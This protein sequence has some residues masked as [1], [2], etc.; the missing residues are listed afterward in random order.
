MDLPR[1]QTMTSAYAAVYKNTDQLDEVAPA[2]A[3]LAGKAAG[4]LAAKG[5]GA[6]AAKM[7]GTAAKMASSKLGQKAIGAGSQAVGNKVQSSL[8][9]EEVEEGSYTSAYL[10]G[11]KPMDLNKMQDKAAMKPDTAKGEKQARKI[12]KIR[13][14]GKH[15][16]PEQEEGAK[17]QAKL[18][19]VNPL[20]RAFKKPSFDKTKNKAYGLEQKRRSD[21]DNRYGPKKEEVEALQEKEGKKDA[22][23]NKVKSRYDVWPS[24]YASG[25]LV[26]CRKAGAK[27]WGN[28]SKKEEVT[29]LDAVAT[30]FIEND[31][32]LSE[33][34]AFDMASHVS[35]DFFS[36]IVEGM[37]ADDNSGIQYRDG[38]GIMGAGE[39]NQVGDG[40]AAKEGAPKVKKKPDSKLDRAG[41]KKP[42]TPAEKAS[43]KKI[44]ANVPGAYEAWLKKK[45]EG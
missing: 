6:G 26:K 36:D 38:G 9:N 24:A 13:A 41:A 4:G 12:D 37:M 21:L 25:A 20:K 10:E 3:A 33:E 11:F 16:A 2:I 34:S 5:A 23:Y 7:G 29:Y 17:L 1:S 32:A 45:T 15:A 19:K 44:L 14:V 35:D 42:P 28:S 18:N 30:F 31:Y 27:N 40:V 8:S 22:C 43:Q 39:V